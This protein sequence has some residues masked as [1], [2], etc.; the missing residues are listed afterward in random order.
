MENRSI[1]AMRHRLIQDYEK[2]KLFGGDGSS[3][4]LIGVAIGIK[5][6]L[7]FSSLTSKN[8]DR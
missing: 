1:F 8:C 5:S 6:P 2:I 3:A 7:P 4:T